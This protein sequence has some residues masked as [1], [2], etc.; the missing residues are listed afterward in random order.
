MLENSSTL[1]NL[2]VP[3]K[4]ANLSDAEMASLANSSA[5][6]SSVLDAYA[7]LVIDAW[8]NGDLKK[9]LLADPAAV[10]AE[11]GVTLPAGVSV[12]AV[13]ASAAREHLVLPAATTSASSSVTLGE[14]AESITGSFTNLTKP[15]T[16]GS[17][18]A[19]MAFSIG[20]IMKFKQ[21]KDNPTQIPIGH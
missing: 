17:Y 5:T 20:A 3:A 11:R 16:A 2:V 8:Q 9:R 12:Q 1:T 15:I 19:G 10:L 13:E 18:L 7:E 6:P 21:H 14:M 4:P